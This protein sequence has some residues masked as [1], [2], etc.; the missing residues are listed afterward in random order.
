VSIATGQAQAI[1]DRDPAAAA[2]V[3]ALVAHTRQ[4]APPS[5]SGQ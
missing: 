5:R 3:N 1:L 4:I 2:Q